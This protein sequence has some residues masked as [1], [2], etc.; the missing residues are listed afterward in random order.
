MFA[1]PKKHIFYR[2]LHVILHHEK[3]KVEIAFKGNTTPTFD[4]EPLFTRYTPCYCIS[5]P[6]LFRPLDAVALNAVEQPFSAVNHEGDVG[7]SRM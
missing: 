3:N 4:I 2:F 5:L 1:I 6:A 7:E